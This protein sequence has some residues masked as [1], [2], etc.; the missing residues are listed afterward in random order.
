MPLSTKKSSVLRQRPPMACCWGLLTLLIG[1]VGLGGGM[2]RR[3]VEAAEP[4]AAPPV[5]ADWL[6]AAERLIASAHPVSDRLAG[7]IE[8]WPLPDELSPLDRQLIISL[9]ADPAA[10]D[11]LPAAAEPLWERFADLRRQRAAWYFAKATTAANGEA[12]SQP[13][14][15]AAAAQETVRLLSRVIREDPD[16]A[17]ARQ[18]LGYVEHDGRWVWP[19]V[20]RRLTRGETY[21]PA[22]GWLR[23]G[24][25]PPSDSRSAEPPSDPP[26]LAAADTFQTAHWQIRSTAGQA[27]AAALAARLEQT[28]DIW[29]QAFGGFAVDPRGLR[30]RLDGRRR[31]RPTAAFQAVLLADRR[32]YIGELQQLEPR[33]AQTLGIYWT[34]TQTAWFFVGDEPPALTIE[35]E[36]THQLFAEY[37]PTNRLAGE[38]CGMWALEAVACHM[39]SLQPTSFGFTLGGRDAGRVPAARERLLNDGFFIPLRDLCNRGRLDLQ[40]DPRLPQIYSQISGLADF[41]LNAQQGRFRGCFLEYLRRIYAGTARADTLWRLCEVSPETLDEAY[42]R[43]LARP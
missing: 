6:E 32:Q 17:Q 16:H 37:R 20:A 30:Q 9:P 13:A 1:L 2:H 36:A 21:S 12:G 5:G 38:R 22:A 43:Y 8:S 24:G 4:A 18:G 28:R 33:I 3:P 31:L 41:F 29:L 19:N 11:W 42:R 34:P 23:A 15:R 35:H 25:P 39:E 26:T 40:R 10:P 27:A 7:L 14:T